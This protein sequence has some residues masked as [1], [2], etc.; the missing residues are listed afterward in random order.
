MVGNITGGCFAWH[1]SQIFWK[2]CWLQL[3]VHPLLFWEEIRIIIPLRCSWRKTCES[4]F[5]AIRTRS[6]W[7]QALTVFYKMIRHRLW[8]DLSITILQCLFPSVLAL[9]LSR[10]YLRERTC[11]AGMQLSRN[12]GLLPLSYIEPMR[13]PIFLHFLKTFLIF[14][15]NRS[16]RV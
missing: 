6:E 14:F 15:F 2:S 8:T 11:N 16:I 13:Y 12:L 3:R 4:P 5:T 9:M 1:R 10:F 7:E